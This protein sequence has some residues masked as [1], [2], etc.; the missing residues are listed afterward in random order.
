M[1][2]KIKTNETQDESQ[3]EEKNDDGPNAKER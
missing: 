1:A 2:K 3:D